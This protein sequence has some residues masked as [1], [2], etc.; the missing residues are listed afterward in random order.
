MSGKSI[1]VLKTA[2]WLPEPSCNNQSPLKHWHRKYQ[3]KLIVPTLIINFQQVQPLVII[4]FPINDAVLW[5]P[6]YIVTMAVTFRQIGI[7]LVKVKQSHYRPGQA[8]RVPEGW[9]S[10]ISRQSTHEGGKVVSPTHRP[11]FTPKKYF[12]YSF[13][14]RGWGDPRA[15]V[16][17]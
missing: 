8:L 13:V 14:L 3:T 11:P 16:R 17:A 15:I 6:F 12:W 1:H 7:S 5:W 4:V 9:G 10:Q 2:M